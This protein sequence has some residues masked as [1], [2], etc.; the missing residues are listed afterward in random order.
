MEQLVPVPRAPAP[1]AEPGRLETA[2]VGA[3]GFASSGVPR[4]APLPGC[5]PSRPL[6]PGSH[7]TDHFRSV[8]TS[9]DKTGR[10]PLTRP[11]PEQG[12]PESQ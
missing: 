4:R 9:Y 7:H 6:K 3:A 10:K 11:L 8:C 12:N 2:V 5:V 1:G